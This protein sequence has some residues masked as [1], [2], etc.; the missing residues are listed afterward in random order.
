M[1]FVPC[2]Y[3]LSLFANLIFFVLLSKANTLTFEANAE[4]FR[5]KTTS[6]HFQLYSDSYT[7]RTHGTEHLCI[8][9]IIG[10]NAIIGN[11]KL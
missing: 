7:L 10:D 4:H 11:G 1:T 6:L 3:R 2:R 5:M 8:F 9:D